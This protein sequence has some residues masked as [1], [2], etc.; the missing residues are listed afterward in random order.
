M[1]RIT[2]RR[3]LTTALLAG[4]AA[5][6]PSPKKTPYSAATDGAEGPFRHGVASGDPGA[7][8]I[9]LWTRATTDGAAPVPLAFEIA[10][11][12]G[13]SEIL[14]EGEAIAAP[15]ADFTA[16]ALVDGLD[17]G[18]IY[19]YRFRAGEAVSPIGRT[20]TLPEGQLDRAAFAIVSCSNY[21]FGYFNVY[22]L[23][24]RRDDLDAVIH[25]GDYIYENG[26]DGYGGDV[27]AALGRNHEPDHEIVT[28]ADYRRRHAQ[29]KADPASRAMHAAHPLIAIWD[30]HESANDSWLG[31]ARN[32]DPATEGDWAARKRAAMQ[33]YYEWMP[34]REPAPG[35][36]REAIFRAFSY[37]DLLTVAALE[38]RL[39]ARAKQ[40]AYSEVTPTLKTREDIDRFRNETLWDPSRAMLGAAQEEFIG[41]TL[42]A[43]VEAGPAWRVIANQVLMGHVLAPDLTP[44]VTEAEIV[45]AEKDWSEARAFV[46]FSKM[47]LPMNLDCW[48]G[49]PAAREKF[50]DRVKGAGADGVLV[51]T[52]DYHTWWANDLAARDGTPMGVELAVHSVTSPSPFRKDAMGGRGAKYAALVNRENKAVRYL[53]GED[54]G[55]IALEIGRTEA[56]AHFMAVDTIER[57]DYNAFEKAVFTIR[58]REGVA[59]ARS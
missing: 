57:P 11:D 26:V 3:A 47:N 37:G 55:Y 19:Y 15:A 45:A 10:A 40:F 8:S 34:I 12:R 32:H 22:D 50:Y 29:Y 58:N 6:S 18:R 46:A 31:G 53:S 2:R 30:D 33:A 9:V 25:L 20:R 23:I 39:M 38:T 36:P 54:H 17:P 42:K 7:R 59:F 49:Y 51:L 56:K 14:R 1:T 13:F 27:G 5:C 48:D 41:E 43:S 44:H 16:K 28:L 52:G 24:A 35:R 4:A 21:P